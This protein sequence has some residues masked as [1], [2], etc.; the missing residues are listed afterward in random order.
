MVKFLNCLESTGAFFKD[1]QII[2]VG[3]AVNDIR[4]LYKVLDMLSTGGTSDC[5]Y[6][7]GYIY[8]RGDLEA[9]LDV[10]KKF[11]IKVAEPL[12]PRRTLSPTL[13]DNMLVM[14]AIFYKALRRYAL[15]K[16]FRMFF[17]RRKRLLPSRPLNELERDGLAYR[18]NADL[19]IVYGLYTKLEILKDGKAILWV[20]LYSPVMKFKEDAIERPL[21]I[22]EIR[23]S[24]VMEECRRRIP[25][26]FQR[27]G[28]IRLL[29]AS[30]CENGKLPIRLAD[31]YT[32]DFRCGFS[33]IEVSRSVQ[34]H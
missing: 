5:D 20:D 12:E 27:E 8:V 24:G 10:L 16:G 26:P 19:A 34:T 4:Q 32:V 2:A 18:I 31:G 30:L 21:D 14:E 25:N 9:T 3:V 28:K 15:G 6:K 17:R 33:S 1:F 11:G 22:K 7:H 23:G 29:L 13:L